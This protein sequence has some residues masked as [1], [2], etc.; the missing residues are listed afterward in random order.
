M[1]NIWAILLCLAATAAPICAVPIAQ[2]TF[3]TNVQTPASTNPKASA[4]S[5][6]LSSGSVTYFSGNAPTATTGISGTGWNVSDGVKSWDF[7]VTANAGYLL[8]LSSLTFDDRAS[9]TGA[10]DWSVAINGVPVV[11]NQS[12]HSAFSTDPMNT[13]GWSATAFQ[14][15]TSANIEIFGYGAFGS[16]GTWRLD[17]VTLNGTVSAVPDLL[18]SCL[19]AVMTLGPLVL[20]RRFAGFSKP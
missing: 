8:D 20:L 2:W 17:N 11:S 10:T 18:P 14:N 13:V 12:T 5:F 4:S 3:E 6:T 15:L 1:K 16:T 9:G 7:T 19:A